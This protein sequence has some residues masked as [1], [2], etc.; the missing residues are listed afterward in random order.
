MSR[1]SIQQLTGSAIALCLAGLSVPAVAQVGMSDD[2]IMDLP[3]EYHEIESQTDESDFDW[4]SDR[5]IGAD[6][7]ETIVR[8]RRIEHR[9]PAHTSQSY[10]TDR[11]YTQA[12]AMPVLER[13]A[14]I[15]EC[16]RRTHG[17]GENEKGG[18]IGG[19]LGAVFGGVVGN[20]VA[21]SGDRLAGTLIGAGAGG[22]G[23]ALLGGL[24]G[25]GKKNGRYDC[26]AA[27]DGYLANHHAGSARLARRVIAAPAY[28]PAMH[29]GSMYRGPVH[30]APAYHHPQ[31]Q[32]VYVPVTYEQ[33]QQV[34]VRETVREET[35]TVPAT[36]TIERPIPRQQAPSPKM[37]KQ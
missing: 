17:R 11:V 30:Y 19:L 24:I 34:I 3:P 13:E 35:Y 1:N 10:E 15:E 31:P 21:G 7:V 32:V 9:A 22:L 4:S 25:G 5:S 20:R 16:E 23:G 37:I 26:E 28:A 2:E 8:T 27:L 36:R 18:I 33:Q 6:G 12:P 14:W 29:H